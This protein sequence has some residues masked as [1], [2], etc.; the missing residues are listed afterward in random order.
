M[1]S[2]DYLDDNRRP[3]MKK[4]IFII[5]ITILVLSLIVVYYTCFDEQ[6]VQP[7]ISNN[8]STEKQEETPM[9]KE[10]DEGLEE[11]KT[12]TEH[13]EQGSFFVDETSVF[14]NPNAPEYDMNEDFVQ[15]CWKYHVKSC[16][17]VT[18]Q[19]DWYYDDSLKYS[20]DKKGNLLNN[21][22]F[23]LVTYRVEKLK[24][25]E[26]RTEFMMN[27]QEVV[28]L[29]RNRKVIPDSSCSYETAMSTAV[30]PKRVKKRD[31]HFMSVNMKPGDV[32]ETTN[33]YAVEKSVLN[34]DNVFLF[35][36]S[37]THGV[38]DSLQ[39]SEHC[40]VRLTIDGI[41]DLEVKSTDDKT[42]KK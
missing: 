15:D 34:K 14:Y 20:I 11:K 36:I 24:T 26:K 6:Q 39:P 40:Y 7:N 21:E 16:K 12:E 31:S 35:Y 13:L 37:P 33:I 18:K 19:G 25:G 9:Q 42:G 27:D 38:V 4:K 10:S 32:L 23:V 29:D 28:V 1:Y 3:V 5:P 22:V 41:D 17:V 30:D 8:S 2:E